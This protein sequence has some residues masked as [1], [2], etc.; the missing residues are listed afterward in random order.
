MNKRTAVDKNGT[1]LYP[2]AAPVTG[3]TYPQPL[4]VHQPFVPLSFYFPLVGQSNTIPR[5]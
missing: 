4:A 1:P 5:Y 3:P 2:G